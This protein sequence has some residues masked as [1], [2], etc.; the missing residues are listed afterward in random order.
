VDLLSLAYLSSMPNCYILCQKVSYK[1]NFLS[2]NWFENLAYDSW[3]SIQLIM[4]MFSFFILSQGI[5]INHLIYEWL[6]SSV[7][8][9]EFCV[10]RNS[11]NSK[12]LKNS[13][14]LHAVWVSIS[15]HEES[16]KWRENLDHIVSYW[17]LVEGKL[18]CLIFADYSNVS[19]NGCWSL[20]WLFWQCT[21][22]IFGGKAASNSSFSCTAQTR[23]LYVQLFSHNI[24]D[25]SGCTSKVRIFRLV[26]GLWHCVLI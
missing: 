23:W 4:L 14:L 7:W 17:L 1:F 10:Q 20:Q 3:S 6:Q 24:S 19:N 22:L 26:V 21:N 9:Q 8:S 16:R 11:N 12:N 13:L 5:P 25:T 15:M 2:W 18:V